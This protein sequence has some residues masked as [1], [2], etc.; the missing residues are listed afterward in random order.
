MGTSMYTRSH[1][2]GREDDRGTPLRLV[3]VAVREHG[4]SRAARASAVGRSEWHL[5]C[6][7]P[8]SPA[9]LAGNDAPTLPSQRTQVSR[10]ER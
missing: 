7:V 5:V 1:H 10:R 4:G 3:L 2:D 6:N 8:A 9:E